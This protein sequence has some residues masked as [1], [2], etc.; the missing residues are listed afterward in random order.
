M[1]FL[2][3]LFVGLIV[4]LAFFINSAL[5]KREERRLKRKLEEPRDRS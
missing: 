3:V 1:L 5:D 4:L 2:V